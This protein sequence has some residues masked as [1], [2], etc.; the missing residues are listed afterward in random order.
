MGV[1]RLP[2]ANHPIIFWLQNQHSKSRHFSRDQTQL[3]D[4]NE[5]FHRLLNQ[6]M[7][8]VIY[9]TFFSLTQG[10]SRMAPN[11]YITRYTRELVCK[12]ILRM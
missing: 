5:K 10:Y 11:K 8:Q 3:S 2:F 1:E 4:A 12:M 6:L 9:S 7:I